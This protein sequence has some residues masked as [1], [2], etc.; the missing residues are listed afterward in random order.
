MYPCGYKHYY[1]VMILN[2]IVVSH[3]QNV[4]QANISFENTVQIKYPGMPITNQNYITRK[5]RLK[6]SLL[7]FSS[8]FVHYLSVMSVFPKP[9][10]LT[11]HFGFEK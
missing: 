11:D 7:P 3:H 9:F 10:L 8:K 1:M 6:K 4:G 5:S 2:I